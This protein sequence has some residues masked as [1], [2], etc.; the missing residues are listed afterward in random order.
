MSD[1]LNKLIQNV[2]GNAVIEFAFMAPLLLVVL[3]GMSEIGRAYFQANAV[4]KGL[5]AGALFAARNAAP[6]SPSAR[7]A[8][9]N[10]VMTG[11]I[12]GSGPFLVPGWS[13]PAAAVDITTTDF[14]LGGDIVPVY[15]FEASVP[16]VPMAGNLMAFVG[17]DNFTIRTSH[18]QAYIGD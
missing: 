17:I 18:E 16:Y 5:R 7:T 13:D 2:K 8:A 12:D 1:S 6:L 9:R 3:S 14:A 4:E 11:T 10:L 15:R